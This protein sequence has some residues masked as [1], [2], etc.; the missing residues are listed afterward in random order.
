MAKDP[1]DTPAM[2]QWTA[3]KRAHPGC[4]LFFRMGDFYEL[5]GEDAE[6]V[7]P[8][9]GLRTMTRGTPVP[10]AGVPYHQLSTY[11]QKAIDAGYRVAVCDQI[12]D[13]KEAKGVVDRAVTRVVTP[14]TLIEEDL[15]GEASVGTLAAGH[16]SA[17]GRVALATI[18]VSTGEFFLC[19]VGPGELADE[20][21]RRAVRELVHADDGSGAVPA[22]C[23]EAAARVGAA[24]T[25]RPAWQFRPRE[26]TE[27]IAA[28]F[29]T[30]GVEGFGLKAD[31]AALLPAGAL[32]AYLC[33]TQAIGATPADPAAPATSGG[34]FQHQRRTLSH[35]R[36]PRREDA[37]G[38]CVLDDVSLRALEIER[39]IRADSGG[40]VSGGV[41]G[42]REDVRGSLLGVFL[43]ANAGPR[44]VV[45]TA[46]GKRMIRRWLTRPLCRAVEVEARQACVAALVEDRR[47]AEELGALLCGVADVARISARVALG[48]ATPRDVVLLAKSVLQVGPIAG[49]LGATPAFSGVAPGLVE[50]EPSLREAAG[51]VLALCVEDAPG[52]M[53][54]GGL[55]RDGVD[56]ELDEARLLQRDAG[57]WLAAYQD[58]LIARHDVPSLKVGF[59][60]VFGYFIELPSAQA[61]RAPDEFRRTQTLKNAERY[62][63]PEL[64]DFER[65][66]TT[67]EERALA[68]ERVLFNGLLAE[69]SRRVGELGRAA[70]LLAEADVLLAFADKAHHRGWAR[71]TVTDESVLEILQ[72]R[73]PVLDELLDGRFVPNDA[74]LGGEAARLALITGPNMAGKS[75]F[76]RQTALLAV[77]ACT[78][79][80]VPAGS[81]RVG[82]FDRVFTRV[83]ADDAL[84]RGQSTFMVEMTETAAILN[85]ATGR[86]LVVLDEIGRGT[87]TLDGLSLAWAIVERLA[88]ERHRGIEAS[89]QGG[90]ESHGATETRSHAGER[91]REPGGSPLVLFATHYHEL[92]ELAERMAG[93]VANW[94][95]AVREWGEE[96]VFVHRIEPGKADRSYGVHVAKLAGVPAAVT[97]RAQEVLETLSV[98]QAGRVDV[99]RVEAPKRKAQQ[100]L[101]LFTE[102][103]P[104]PAVDVLRGVKIEQMSPMQAFEALRELTAMVK[105]TDG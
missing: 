34:E 71:P 51:R 52:S 24:T 59:N 70:D 73:H 94:H 100:Q 2:R 46:M 56:A 76:I 63:T 43:E 1:Y 19:D 87:S 67:A 18:D 68:R 50:V 86:S 72:G 11:L 97:A 28:Q 62:T 20:L 42:R 105:K 90:Q 35:L 69:V 16:V 27:A 95:V 29:G 21:V 12:Q 93:R 22:W 57:A 84:H 101:G 83:G 85:N 74:R 39:I 75:T 36:P 5:F 88:G 3:F 25:P 48:R 58:R 89:R 54:G 23:R 47:A 81:A 78:G 96:I 26:A 79:S 65:K 17:D 30:A 103:V 80:F 92:T 33:E 49:L 8:A 64:S 104:H 38:V 40:G 4:V 102:Y 61:R 44:S 55:I 45:R 15:L 7:A 31:D 53:R 10:T 41:R 60:K 77:L 91:Q 82:T 6:V 99:S 32:L 98:Q 13:P 9:L 14:G 37:G 66:V